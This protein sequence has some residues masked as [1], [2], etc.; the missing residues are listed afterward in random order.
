MNATRPNVSSDLANVARG[1]AMGGADIIPG[2]SGGTVALILGI[3]Y[4]LVSAISHVDL[5]LLDH[6]RNRRWMAAA[7]HLD[8]RFLI[9]LGA[10]IATGIL[11]LAHVMNWLLRHDQTRLLT[12][13]VF[14]GL[15]G[16]SAVVVARMIKI[17]RRSDFAIPAACG[18]VGAW[19]A[20]WLTGL[21]AL[22]ADP[23][24]GYVLLCGM[25]A[26]CAMILPGISGAFIL[27]IL[28][29][30][31]YITDVLRRMTSLK[32]SA[33][34]F[35][36]VGVFCVGCGVGLIFFS[37]FLKWLLSQHE[38]PTM[39]L[40]C[41]FMVGSL[42]KIWPFK[43]DITAEHLGEVG[44]SSEKLA[45]I[46]SGALSVADL[47]ISHRMFENMLPDTFDRNVLLVICLAIAAGTFVMIL[48]RVTGASSKRGESGH[49]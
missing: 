24:L 20:Y 45:D 22:S 43:R 15:I 33:D 1:F 44:L 48:D 12:L 8:L 2:V 21:S 13:A 17:S 35:L 41:G 26:I 23:S 27:L 39:G 36:T 30:Y 11:A 7:E 37:K 47:D 16:A 6:L 10:G 31:V 4:R 38:A 49:S 18:V 32:F 46:Q 28:G 19:F 40:L 9:A 3:Y 25:V 29:M 14:F 5:V 34:D 42:R